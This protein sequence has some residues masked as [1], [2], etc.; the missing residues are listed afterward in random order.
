MND[1]V[2]D[3]AGIEPGSRLAAAV[4]ARADIFE[5]TQK[6]HDAALCPA[7]PGGLSHALRAA[8]ALRIAR[9]NTIHDFESH[10][11]GLLDQAGADTATR[12]V[13]DL[14]F[15]GGGDARI[16]A[17]IRHLDLVAADPKSASG[18]DIELLRQAGVSDADIVRLSELIA[19]VSY[20]IRVVAGLKVVR[21]L[22]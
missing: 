8:L 9:L 14:G 4:Q 19:F 11:A 7:E 17:L 5:L 18:N 3:I 15:D 13:A 16:D 22:P 1:V 21:A 12:R 2:L 20:Q 6:T 10:F